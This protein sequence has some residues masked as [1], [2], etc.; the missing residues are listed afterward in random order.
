[1][2]KTPVLFLL[3]ALLLLTSCEVEFSPNAQWKDIPVVYCLLDPDDDTVF[4]RVERCF[5]GDGSIYDYGII[6]DSI[7]YPQG[8][9][10]VW[11]Y[12]FRGDRAV[13]SVQMQYTLRGRDEGA[14][15]STPQPVYYSVTPL[16]STCRYSLRVRRTTDNVFIAVTDTIPLICQVKSN[17]IT[18]PANN[19]PYGFSF[20]TRG[21]CRI[22]WPALYAARRY[23]P[24]VRFYYRELDDTLYVDLP[25]GEVAANSTSTDAT[26]SFEYP[27]TSFL[28]S[29][30]SY[31]VGIGDTVTPKYYLQ[32]VDLFLT[33]W[34]ENL[35]VYM[36][37][38]ASGTN[39][40]QTTDVYTNVHGGTGIFASRLIH[41][42][43]HTLADPSTNP[44]GSSNP[45]LRAYLKDL[46]I[47]FQ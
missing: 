5:L 38:V 44:M 40:N 25:A 46:G 19:D 6:A 35:N 10:D 23:H 11:L 28:Y 36:M 27:R 9:I 30:R 13:D 43:K 34:D 4:A 16:D 24:I 21:A 20:M 39:L 8:A 47:G 17:L 37:S 31:F 42:Y 22:E 1:M 33:A 26:Y 2:K 32:Y 12:K 7:N 3:A 29:L 41:R 45:S 15:A 18:R 14:F